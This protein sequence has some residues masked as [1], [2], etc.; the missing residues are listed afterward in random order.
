MTLPLDTL[1]VALYTIVDD[2]YQK[3]FAPLK[4]TR[5]GGTLSCLTARSYSDTLR[6]RIGL[7]GHWYAMCGITGWRSFPT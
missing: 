4:P 5:P 3:H 6:G 7:N 2:L 1:L